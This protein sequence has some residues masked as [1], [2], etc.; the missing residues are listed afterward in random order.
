MK[1]II[2]GLEVGYAGGGGPLVWLTDEQKAH[3]M[4]FDVNPRVYK[5]AS[6][7]KERINEGKNWFSLYD[8]ADK[9]LYNLLETMVGLKVITKQ[10]NKSKTGHYYKETMHTNPWC[11]TVMSNQDSIIRRRQTSDTPTT[12]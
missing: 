12:K 11:N 8:V 1:K 7:I 3:A 9:E 4:S 2:D 6:K 5:M 10:A